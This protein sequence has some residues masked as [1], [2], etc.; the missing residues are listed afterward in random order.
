MLRRFVFPLIL[1]VNILLLSNC[2][3][4]EQNRWLAAHR[5][6][7]SNLAASN[8]S[9]EQKV[10]GLLTNYT[11]LMDEGLRFVNPIK[12]VK[13]IEKFQSQNT[14]AIDQILGSSNAWLNNLS[15]GE[16]VILGLRVVQ[17][18]YIG[19]VIDLVPKFHRKY[20]QY[21]FILNLT[22]KIA[23]GFGKLGAKVIGF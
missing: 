11:V 10:D 8:A 14:P 6:E 23:G 4:F 1:G 19:K 16:T 3:S 21:K 18:P 13:Y 9:A 15:D 2:A 17:K 5:N 20:E 22:G 12:G 7:L